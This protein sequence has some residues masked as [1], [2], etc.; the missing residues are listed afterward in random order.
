MSY[1]LHSADERR[2]REL[3]VEIG[4]QL[5]R[6][7]LVDGTSGNI[8]ARLAPDRILTTPS[9]VAKGFLNPNDLLVVNS[10]GEKV[11]PQSPQTRDL[12]PTSELLMHLEAYR[13][14]P[15]IGGVVHAHPPTT[16]ALSIAGVS[17]ERCQIP[18]AVVILGLVPTTEYATPS[19]VEN[20][21]AISE[22]VREHDAI[23]L[24]FHG[25]LVVGKDAWDAYLKTETLE[26]SAKI[27][28]M[29]ERLGGGEWLPPFQVDKLMQM[30][31]DLGL[32]RPGDVERFC[33]VCGASHVDGKHLIDEAELEARIRESVRKSL[34]EESGKSRPQ[35]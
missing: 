25:S 21:Q 15:D 9:G 13:Q 24:R 17:L 29:V 31:Q 10:E 7:N 8:S 27:I 19:S 35:R 12:R 20:Q 22:L 33:E 2:A 26:H 3:I 1:V 23:I 5:H 11:G 4:R 6:N 28:Y 18:E 30:R 32:G 14:R 16:V 34:E